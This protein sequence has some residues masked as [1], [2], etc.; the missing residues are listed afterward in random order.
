VDE[1]DTI[2][3]T[4]SK[5][6]NITNNDRPPAGAAC[7]QR[8]HPARHP[9]GGDILPLRASPSDEAA[10]AGVLGSMIVDSGC[11]PDVK[12][13]VEEAAFYTL[14]HKAIFSAIMAVYHETTD[15]H[16]DGLLVVAEL[17]RRNKLAA[18]GGR[19]YVQRIMDTVPSA[20][21]AVH[22]SKIVQ[23]K[24]CRRMAILAGRKLIEAA[25]NPSESI[26]DELIGAR[27]DLEEISAPPNT[28]GCAMDPSYVW[29]HGVE[30]KPVNWLWRGRFPSAMLSLL[31]G[32][33][34]QGKSF[35]ALDIATH[36]SRGLAWPDAENEA[37]APTVGNV[38][39]MTTECHLEY[40]VKPRLEAMK[41][42]CTRIV[43]MKGILGTDGT[44]TQF[45]IVHHLPGLEKM[46]EI[47]KPVR[48]LI[49]DPITGFL[50]GAKQNDTGE[51]RMV[52]SRFTAVAERHN[53]AVIGISH[54]CKDTSKQAIHRTIG[55]TAF[56][57][58]ARATW[59]I[60]QDK[61]DKERRLLVPMKLNL[62]RM[63]RSLAFRITDS[64]VVWEPGQYEYE[65]NEVLA[66]G[67]H[68]SDSVARAEAAEWL[69]GV[70]AAGR[71]RSI[72]IMAM[73]KK[74]NIAIR[75]LKRAKKQ[76]GV[77]SKNDG[78]G[79]D[80]VWYWMLPEGTN[81]EGITHDE[82]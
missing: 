57:G 2:V 72:E 61:E 64:A 54:L 35:V 32:I 81:T 65:A 59:L 28:R 40:E 36:V 1:R 10:E 31:V 68:D 4:M 30:A 33:E 5:A 51:M 24:Y 62:V 78:F 18:V 22:Y 67:G 74:E 26:A 48:L 42:D 73:A 69:Q 9:A 15:T 82:P 49:V 79:G 3:D 25:Y 70:L 52:L 11:I 46:L 66:T 17:E 7:R 27:L 58:T 16:V 29:M 14:E 19:Q 55:S 44:E 47:A 53:C 77:V 75:T 13:H 23:E 21:N 76:I 80:S 50:G 38:V 39:Y 43:A 45:D 37:D 6:V 60:S 8:T 12:Q 20:A 56:I 63:A 41:A 71:V 34:G